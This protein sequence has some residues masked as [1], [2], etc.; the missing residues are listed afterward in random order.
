MKERPMAIPELMLIAGTR[1]ALGVGIGLLIADQ[2]TPGARTAIGLTLVTLGAVTTAPI[3][4][5]ILSKPVIEES[6]EQI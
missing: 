6:P 1:V 2:I 3:L 4:M 5:D